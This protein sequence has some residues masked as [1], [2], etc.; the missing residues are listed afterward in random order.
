M[1]KSIKLAIL[2][3]GILVFTLI[4]MKDVE[5]A[6]ASISDG[7]T[8]N[9]GEQVTVTASV[10][11][12][13]WNLNLSGA[14][15]SKSLVGQTTIEGNSSDSTSITFTASQ[16][17]TYNFSLSGDMTDFSK[18]VAEN[19]SESATITVVNATSNT[20]QENQNN[21]QDNNE[22]SNTDTTPSQITENTTKSNNANLSNLGITP[23]DFS[24]F[25]PGITSYNVTVENDVTSIQVYANVQDSKSKVSGTGT[26][27]LNEGNNELNVVVTAEDGT[28][29]TYTI[30]VTRKTTE[31]S[32]DDTEDEEKTEEENKLG[33]SELKIEGVELSPDFNSDIYE[34]SVKYIGKETNL[35]ITTKPNNDSAKVEIVGNE[36]LIDGEN[37][38]NILVTD[39]TGENTVT[40]QITVNKSLV[41]EK[42][43]AKQ[44]TEEQQKSNEKA[45]AIGIGA[46]II[47]VIIIV[48]LILKVRNKKISDE[49]SIRYSDFD[50]DNYDY[51]EINQDYEDD[52]E[53]EDEYNNQI[54]EGPSNKKKAKGKRFK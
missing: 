29:K 30:N 44:K 1:K 5:A 49:Y 37:L 23:N 28:T 33:L 17:G 34:Y 13:A 7:K 22:S 24:G 6:S 16:A 11:A 43:L 52:E 36:N 14:G 51:E 53:Q 20:E 25:K 15:Q 2:T 42:A 19:V 41:D 3:L 27:S 39:D 32:D 8:V 50:E 46:I 4:L 9:V 47:L 26:K 18:E 10:T 31:E 40:Y 35:D 21:I 12:G 38:I 54:L 45:I 48:L